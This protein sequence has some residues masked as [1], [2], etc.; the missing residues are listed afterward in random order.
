MRWAVA[1][2]IGWLWMMGATAQESGARYGIEPDLDNYPQKTP[3]VALE[4]ILKA[5]QIKKVDYLLAQLADPAFVDR[6]VKEVHGGKFEEMVKETTSKL[7]DD[8]ETVP[9]LRRFLKEGEWEDGDDAVSA[10]LKDVKERLF[11]RKSG[12]RWFLENRK[13]TAK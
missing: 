5:I 4:S 12:G 10:K 3:K 9:L 8:P 2:L 1:F 13:G 6:R 11:F 7:I